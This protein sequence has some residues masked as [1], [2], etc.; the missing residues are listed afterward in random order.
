MV[1]SLHP[2]QLF[3]CQVTLRACNCSYHLY[4]YVRVRKRRACCYTGKLYVLVLYS[5]WSYIETNLGK[6]DVRF[7]FLLRQCVRSLTVIVK[8]NNVN[9][10]A[11]E[12]PNDVCE[13]VCIST[14]MSLGSVWVQI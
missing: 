6:L 3:F 10:T 11:C 12:E 14:V 8:D 1:Y 5:W 7:S 2:P 13:S 9:R 4:S